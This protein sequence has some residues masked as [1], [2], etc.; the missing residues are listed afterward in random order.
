[1]TDWIARYPE[2]VIAAIKIG[3]MIFLLLTAV[4]YAVWFERKV[5]AHIQSR[6]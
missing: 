4:A 3:V 2:L 6:W 5:I 1:M